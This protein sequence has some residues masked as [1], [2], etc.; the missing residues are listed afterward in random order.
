MKRTS[1]YFVGPQEVELR[2]EN[3]PAPAPGQ[4][5]VR[6]LCSA[7][8]A[9]TEM[10]IYRGQAPQALVADT[11]IAALSGSLAFPLK[12]GYSMVGKVASL[13]TYV[14]ASLQGQRV[15]AFNPHETAF[16]ADVNDLQILPETCSNEDAI[17]L[18]NMETAVGLI[19]D[20]APRLGEKVVVL[21]QGVIGLLVTALLAQHPL[22]QLIAVDG[23]EMRRDFSRRFGAH[24]CISPESQRLQD[25]S[26]S[27]LVY[28]L[29]GNPEALNLALRLVGEHGRIVVGSWYGTR[30]VPIHFGEM[31]HRG[32]VKIISS[33]VSQIEPALRGR[34]D[35]A[36]R[37]EQA[38]KWLQ[39]IRPSQL[40]THRFAF[41]DA[42]EAYQLL[43]EQPGK[44]LGVVFKY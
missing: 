9:G 32:R 33:Q 24:E 6:S 3:L 23:I 21:G 37:F 28:E 29:T 13:G 15:F 31:F 36:R 7:V 40:I 34:W 26:G 1:L 35:K 43:A 39:K 25:A 2:E 4:A 41:D 20:G 44:V 30:Q 5:Q 11:E 27:D 42:P 17:F 12:F 10:L 18:A 8:S 14:D 16:N 22:D 19:M 38:W